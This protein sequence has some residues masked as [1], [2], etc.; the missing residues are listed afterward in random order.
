MLSI[1]LRRMSNFVLN[2][3]RQRRPQYRRPANYLFSNLNVLCNALLIPQSSDSALI[4]SALGD[5]QSDVVVL[6]MGAELMN[7]VNNRREQGL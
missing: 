3:P 1:Y 6:F 4:L 2:L 5:D 7:V